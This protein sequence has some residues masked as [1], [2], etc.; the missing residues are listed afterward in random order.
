MGTVLRKHKQDTTIDQTSK[1]NL[2]DIGWALGVVGR[3]RERRG[4]EGEKFSAQITFRPRM[5]KE[6]LQDR[7]KLGGVNNREM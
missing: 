3:L 7:K 6:K 5:S 2:L 4:T 1:P